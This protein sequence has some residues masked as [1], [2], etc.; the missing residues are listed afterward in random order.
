MSKDRVRDPVEQK[1]KKVE[2]ASNKPKTAEKIFSEQIRMG[3]DLHSRSSSGLF[4][5]SLAAGL[6]I[7]FT[8]FLS[9]IIYTM[10]NGEIPDVFLQW[11]LALTYPVGFIL[12]IIGR[13]E[14]FTEHTTLAVVPVLNRYA[15]MKSLARVWGLV[16]SG[17]LLGGLI[18]GMIL[19]LLGT[20]MDIISREGFY[21]LAEK[22]IRHDWGIILASGALAGWLM[23][24]LSWLVTSAQETISR[25]VIVFLITSLIGMGGLH[26]SIIGSIEVMAGVL[27]S[28]ISVG[29]YVHFLVWTTLGNIFG[30]AVFVSVLKFN[31]VK[32]SQD[33]K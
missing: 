20:R 13:S 17:N 19:T 23:G 7:G 2:D 4:V 30:G 16:Y 29:Q 9:G 3:L 11:V 14:L 31:L 21:H 22:L 25:I 6:E 12:V 28:D 24:L 27:V 10:F 15:S 5:S 18:I 26:H 33:D 8:L 1:T 32:F